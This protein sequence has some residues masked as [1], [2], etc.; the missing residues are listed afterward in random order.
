MARKTIIV[1]LN[2]TTLAALSMATLAAFVNGPGLGKPVLA[3]LRINDVGG[4]FVPR[5]ADRGDGRDAR[6]HHDR[7]QRA[8]RERGPR[9]RRQRPRTR[10]I[11][12]AV[13]GVGTLVAVYL[14]RTYIGLAEFPV[15]TIGDRI[16]DVVNDVMRL[17][18]QHLR[19]R[20]R[21]LQGR[22]HHLA[23]S[24]RCSR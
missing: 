8:R 21:R 11:I 23:S 20:H 1:G 12:L 2:Q 19:W 15:Y 13:G 16:A 10:R 24:T 5:R 22:R 17:D 7:G 9:R 14:S 4:A 6:P 3:G 18:H